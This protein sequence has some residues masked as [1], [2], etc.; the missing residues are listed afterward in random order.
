MNLFTQ[1]RDVLSTQKRASLTALAKAC[2]TT[3]E[4]VEACLCFYEHKGC[5]RRRN[6]RLPCG[7]ACQQCDLSALVV[8]E[9]V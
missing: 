5:V 2:Q 6:L 1:I 4:E 9:W 3:S 8:Y 7:T